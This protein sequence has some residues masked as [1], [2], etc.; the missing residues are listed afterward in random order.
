MTYE[1]ILIKLTSIC[2]KGEHCLSEMQQKMERWQ[3]DIDTQQRVLRYLV[4]EK[5]IDEGR[6]ARFFINDKM[7]Y[8]KWGKKKI[9]QAL[10]IKRISPDTYQEVLNSIADV[11]Y[12]E[13]LL[14]LLLNK[15]K[16]VKAKDDYE[17]RMKLIRYAMQRGFS[18]DQA[19]HCLQDLTF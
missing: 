1:Q 8:N 13:T 14:P 5:Y 4:E 10:R 7:K 6:F 15:S 12:E 17:K 9:E 16:N 11:S 19:S 3:V 2:A 18:Y